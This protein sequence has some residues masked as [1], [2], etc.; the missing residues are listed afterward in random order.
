MGV[1]K[2][3]LEFGLYGIDD[4]SLLKICL[5]IFLASEIAIGTGSLHPHTVRIQEVSGARIMSRDLLLVDCCAVAYRRGQGEEY[6]GDFQDSES[7]N[8]KLKIWKF[9]FVEGS[10][11]MNFEGS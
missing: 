1:I 2:G 10:L 7:K 5:Q 11:W 8:I 3:Y 4:S 6:P 9:D